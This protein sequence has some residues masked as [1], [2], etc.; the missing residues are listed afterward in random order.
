VVDW[1]EALQQRWS[2]VRLGKVT[3]KTDSEYHLFEVQLFPGETDPNSVRVEL[4]ADGT[5]RDT[6]FRQEMKRGHPLEG[7]GYAY[8]A[9]V[10]A[11]RAPGDYTVRVVP[12]F[13]GAAIPLEA[14]QI[15][16]QRR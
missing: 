5:S 10:P 7:T 2:A 11:A 13:S 14:S 1:Q 8:C 9:Q 15:L 16:W 3:V 4:Y 12:Y 6:P